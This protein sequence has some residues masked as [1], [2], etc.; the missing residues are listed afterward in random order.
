MSRILFPTNFSVRSRHKLNYAIALA[1]QLNKDICLLHVY[2]F[3]GNNSRLTELEMQ[4]LV[5]KVES[6]ILLQFS[7]FVKNVSLDIHFR[8]IIKRGTET[9]TIINLVKDDSFGWLVIGR[10]QG[11]NFKDFLFGNRIEEIINSVKIPSLIV[12]DGIHY[13][14]I[15]KI[16]YAC[17]FIEDNILA[18][19]EVDDFARLFNAEIVFLHVDNNVTTNDQRIARKYKR[20]LEKLIRSK[21]TLE[22]LEHRLIG[23][24][25]KKYIEDNNIDLL[26]MLKKERTLT[27]KIFNSSLTEKMLNIL[28]TKP[29]LV[30]QEESTLHN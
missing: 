17:N 3:N 15:K 6:K 19:Q 24:T 9:K 12:P 5:R 11:S 29:V 27:A 21:F 4:R 22:I 10:N 8:H 23:E 26:V 20:A 7:E 14:P 2:D 1:Q 30:L 13:Q 16:V 18:L 28:D 25:I